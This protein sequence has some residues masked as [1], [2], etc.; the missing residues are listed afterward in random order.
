MVMRN[1]NASQHARTGTLKTVE[2]H[3]ERTS[4]GF[5]SIAQTLIPYV[6]SKTITFTAKSLKPFT[7]MYVY[8]DKRVDVV[9][10]DMASNTS[11]NKSLDSYKTGELC[12][13]AMDLA[14]KILH[15]DGVFL[16]KV[17]MGSIF[18]E[19]DKKAKKCFKK[20]V[21]FK[22]LSSRKESKEIYIFCRCMRGSND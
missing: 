12:I 19:I 13:K 7:K 22:P 11:G 8:F 5:A 2:E 4:K 20:V 15:R 17:F 14:Q 3:I 6:R 16:S 1:Y 9:M 18:I 21:K 10:S